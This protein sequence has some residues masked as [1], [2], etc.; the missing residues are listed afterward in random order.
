MVYALRFVIVNFYDR[1]PV[2]YDIYNTMNKIQWGIDAGLYSAAGANHNIEVLQEIRYQVIAANDAQFVDMGSSSWATTGYKQWFKHHG[3]EASM[4]EYD[5][6]FFN[7]EMVDIVNRLE[8][9]AQNGQDEENAIDLTGD[10]IT[11]APDLEIDLGYLT[12]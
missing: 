5:E 6:H 8:E 4:E 11:L 2:P 3:M 10:I 1:G 9:E 7:Q 12:Q